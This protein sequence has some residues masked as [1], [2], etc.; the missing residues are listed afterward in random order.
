MENRLPS[1][2]GSPLVGLREANIYISIYEGCV[3][4]RVLIAPPSLT[5]LAHPA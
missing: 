4:V 2:L 5:L 1:L 3:K